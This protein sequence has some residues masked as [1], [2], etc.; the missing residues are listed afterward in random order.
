MKDIMVRSDKKPK[1]NN[2]LW[3]E[4]KTQASDLGKLDEMS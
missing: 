1:K 4:G 2:T 3:E